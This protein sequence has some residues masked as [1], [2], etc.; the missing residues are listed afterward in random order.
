[1]RPV[2]EELSTVH[3][4]IPRYLESDPRRIHVIPIK[5]LKLHRQSFP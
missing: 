1:L 2:V 3:G 4:K 5:L